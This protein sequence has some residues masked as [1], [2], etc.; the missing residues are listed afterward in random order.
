MKKAAG[1][2]PAFQ[3]EGGMRPALAHVLGHFYKNP[4]LFGS[5]ENPDIAR[6]WNPHDRRLTIIFSAVV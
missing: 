5:G 4:D 3:G 1:G 2:A 6:G